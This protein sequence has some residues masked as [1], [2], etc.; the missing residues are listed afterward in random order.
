MQLS[1]LVQLEPNLGGISGAACY[2]TVG[3][4][5][6]TK[7]LAQLQN[8]HP[9]LSSSLCSLDDVHTQSAPTFEILMHILTINLPNLQDSLS[10]QKERKPIRLVIIDS[11]ASLFQASH[12][13]T[14]RTLRERSK[15]LSELSKVAHN[16]AS[17]C[18]IA[19]VFV[20]DVSDVFNEQSAE[21]AGNREILYRDQSRWFSSTPSSTRES[22]KE[23]SLGLVWANHLNT[24]IMLAKTNKRVQ[25]QVSYGSSKRPK[26]SHPTIS[27]HNYSDS[28]DDIV[29]A[30]TLTVIFS[31]VAMPAAIDYIISNAGI[32]SIGER[33]PV[34]RQIQ[35]DKTGPS[36]G[37]A[38]G[39]SSLTI[40][41]IGALPSTE[42]LEA[43]DGL[44][45]NASRT[46][47]D[48]DALLNEED[49]DNEPFF[50]FYMTLQ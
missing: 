45:G 13:Q 38:P 43:W 8:D 10:L 25:N 14:S 15:A 19:V 26:L 40:D 12:P 28:T 6:P 23:A 30:R 37:P 9:K 2:I 18:N 48:F 24:R 47:I 44:D 5:L 36:E 22:A 21:N 4:K 29:T 42:T 35:N 27:S 16:L 46:A 31:N 11:I 20:N 3:A 32:V 1:L 41:S 33:N 39:N 50:S 34:A 49:D 17:M 7:R